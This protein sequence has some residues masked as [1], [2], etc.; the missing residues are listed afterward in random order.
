MYYKTQVRN[1]RTKSEERSNVI[2]TP[3]ERRFVI[4]VV[5]GER[6]SNDDYK[7]LLARFNEYGEI[8][9]HI[10]IGDAQYT[11]YHWTKDRSVEPAVRLKAM[12]SIFHNFAEENGWDLTHAG[13]YLTL[14][15]VYIHPGR[16]GGFA[17]EEGTQKIS[18]PLPDKN[19]TKKEFKLIKFALEEHM[20]LIDQNASSPYMATR[21]QQAEKN[22]QVLDACNA[23]TF[24]KRA[25]GTEEYWFIEYAIS[26]CCDIANDEES[27]GLSKVPDAKV[28]TSSCTRL[29]GHLRKVCGMSKE[30]LAA[31]PVDIT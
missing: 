15:T 16:S 24:L 7:A 2:M 23:A 1:N 8:N 20:R 3:E 28:F 4:R 22:Q 12:L 18:G 29:L 25:I 31:G 19:L 14:T 6:I 13:E 9:Q 5:P 26:E 17:D 11:E 21:R 27:K 30:K 10:R